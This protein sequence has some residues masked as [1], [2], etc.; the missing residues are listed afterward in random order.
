MNDLLKNY[1]NDKETWDKCADTYEKRIVSGHPDIVAFESFEEDFLDYLLKYLSI[2][3]ERPIKILDIG[4]GSGRLH[5]FFGAK[6]TR[7]N[8]LPSTSPY[9]RIKKE[10]SRMA[11]SPL[12][13]E[14]LSE[15]WGIDFSGQMIDMAKR[16][17]SEAGFIGIS[18]IDFS[19]KLGSAFKLEPENNDILPVAVC[20][21]N[22]IGVM[23]GPEG[24]ANIFK[25]MR[26]AVDK[27]NGIAIIA[28]YQ[29]EY[30]ETYGLGQYESTI[31]VSGQPRWMVPDT[32]ASEGY[33]Q[34]A[35]DYKLAYSDNQTLIVDVYDVDG[36]LIKEGHLL[37]RDPDL[38]KKTIESGKIR[39]YT[40][41]RSHWY[42][43][44]QFDNWIHKYWSDNSY[45]VKTKEL[46][47]VRAE[48]G[49]IAIF[50]PGNNLE[51]LFGKLGIESYSET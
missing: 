12:L 37:K 11:F 46:D 17:L 16:K 35:R 48:P 49:Q 14:K 7:M 19:F 50:D 38:V 23:Q 26:R 10:Q 32:Y 1:L 22:S 6:T 31:D 25:S 33:V 8:D 4:C 9:Y 15:V 39:T 21:I 47:I 43:F 29:Q 41:Y 5:L 28:A 20:L 44:Q 2:T 13:A 51:R 30:L 34:L 27:A 42:N 18:P 40:N 24:A 45:H 36:N 3:Q